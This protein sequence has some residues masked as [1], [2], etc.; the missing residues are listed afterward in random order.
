MK[1][2]YVLLFLFV[3]FSTSCEFF[4]KKEKKLTKAEV[5]AK[6]DS[7]RANRIRNKIAYDSASVALS[8][9]FMKAPTILKFD[10]QI[11]D[12]GTIKEG[13]KVNHK[14]IYTNTGKNPLVIFTAIGSCGCTQPEF[15]KYPLPPGASDTLSFTFNSKGKLG[16]HTKTVTVFA[17]TN[18]SAN[19]FKFSVKVK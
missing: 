10:K 9:S 3:A 4:N 2:I 6:L 18:P 1:K 17:N 14:V 11:Y 16:N 5:K 12:L 7:L 8:D 15:K 13:E 19:K